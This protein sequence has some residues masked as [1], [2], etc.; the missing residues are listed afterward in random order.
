MTILFCT[1]GSICEGG[2]L[3]ALKESG[4]HVVEF[5]EKCNDVNYDTSYLDSLNKFLTECTPDCLFSVNYIPIISRLCNLLNIT[6]Y[7]WTVDNPCLTL[8]SKTI[9]NPCNR[10]FLFDRQQAEKFSTHNP[11]HIHH[12]PLGCDVSVFD[13]PVTEDDHVKYDCDVSFIGSLYTERCKYDE[14][15]HKLP[16]YIQGYVE[17]ILSAQQNVYGYNFIEDSL[18]DELAMEIKKYSEYEIAPDYFDDIK[19]II[20]HYYLGYKCTTLERINVLKHVS[21]C[22]STDI[23]STSDTSMIPSIRNRGIADTKWMMP[24][25]FKC[26]KINLNITLRSITSGIPQ[27]V[28]DIMGSGGFVISNYQPELAEFFVPGEDIVLYDSI[29]DLLNKIEYYLSNEQE[30][31]QIARNGYEKV[32]TLHSYRNKLDKILNTV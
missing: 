8:Y 20:A 19:G 13:L 14:F 21:S 5:D 17:G 31:L 18:T 30:R 10:I 32:K 11:G 12:L 29:P 25:I 1:W 28:F 16:E 26:S 22:F 24:R 4:Y 2:I 27:R 23:Y 9:T 3:N 7:S 6:Y 15:A